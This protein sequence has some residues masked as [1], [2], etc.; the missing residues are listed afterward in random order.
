MTKNVPDVVVTKHQ[1]GS[2]EAAERMVAEHVHLRIASGA[3]TTAHC[4]AWK[5]LVKER[6]AQP[7]LEGSTKGVR[8][9]TEPE[10]WN[11]WREK[12]VTGMRHGTGKHQIVRTNTQLGL[13][14]LK[15]A[16]CRSLDNKCWTFLRLT[17][18]PARA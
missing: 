13:G 18:R 4:G 5:G 7:K 6:H 15:V 14:R 2:I 8:L 12:P 1:G 10:A 17:A 3:T 16:S 11:G 9:Q